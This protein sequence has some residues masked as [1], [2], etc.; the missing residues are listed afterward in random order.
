MAELVGAVPFRATA[1]SSVHGPVS[2]RV[3][4]APA[5]G[6]MLRADQE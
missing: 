6:R 5:M 4:K 2:G 1:L 3:L